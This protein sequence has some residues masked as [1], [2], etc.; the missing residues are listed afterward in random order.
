MAPVLRV[1]PNLLT[2]PVRFI[3]TGRIKSHRA[4]WYDTKAIQT[5]GTCNCYTGTLIQTDGSARNSF[6]K[7][8]RCSRYGSFYS[9][10]LQF[11]PK[12][13]AEPHKWSCSE[14]TKGSSPSSGSR[15]SWWTYKPNHF[16]CTGHQF[17]MNL[18]K[19]VTGSREMKQQLPRVASCVGGSS[20]VLW[21]QTSSRLAAFGGMAFRACSV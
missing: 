6:H 2:H 4:A 10:S 3:S 12:N 14:L 9:M 5:D 20:V 11:S 19:W 1:L 15:A 17:P 8:L 7:K 21:Q 13:C 18:W 16:S